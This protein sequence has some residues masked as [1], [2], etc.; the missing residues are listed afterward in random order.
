MHP[1][2]HRYYNQPGN[3]YTIAFA[4]PLHHPLPMPCSGPPSDSTLQQESEPEPEPGPGPG[5]GSGSGSGSEIVYHFQC[6]C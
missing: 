4:A 3:N 5:P 6:G 1:D 2:I